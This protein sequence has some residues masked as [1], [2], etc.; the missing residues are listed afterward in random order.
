MDKL[1]QSILLGG[2]LSILS[3]G[4]T[5]EAKVDSR[6]IRETVNFVYDSEV[7]SANDKMKVILGL[8]QDIVAA[9]E[10]SAPQ[11]QHHPNLKQ[12]QEVKKNPSFTQIAESFGKRDKAKLVY[13]TTRN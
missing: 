1:K 11:G 2:I 9:I 6:Q 7:Y 13:L 4:A 12:K 10:T 5:I 3:A 8:Q